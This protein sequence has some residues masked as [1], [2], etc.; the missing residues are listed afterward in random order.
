MT[1]RGFGSRLGE[2]EFNRRVLGVPYI[3]ARAAGDDSLVGRFHFVHHHRAHAACA[4]HASPFPRAAILVVDGIGETS[5]AWLGRGSPEGLE[6]VEEI[7]YPHSIGMLWER[8]AVYLG[9]TEFDACK[10]MGLTAYGDARRF[11]A[12]YDRLFRLVGP[13]GGLSRQD[14]PPFLIDP[15]AGAASQRRRAGSRVALRPATDC[16]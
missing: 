7:G 10:V 9:F 4:F 16:R 11:I 3:L 15:A 13:D 5:T 2:E 8:V 14:G 12:E 6:V 1:T